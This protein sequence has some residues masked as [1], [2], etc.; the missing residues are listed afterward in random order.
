MTPYEDVYGEQPPSVASYLLG[1]SKMHTM[2]SLIHN[3]EAILHI[4]KE[5]F[6]MAH[7]HKKT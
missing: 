7:N 1:I 4:L 2:D 3:L 5:N 6:A